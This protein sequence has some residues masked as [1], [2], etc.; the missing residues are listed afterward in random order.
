MAVHEESNPL[1]LYHADEQNRQLRCNNYAIR[2]RYA[3]GLV[4][5]QQNHER[6]RPQGLCA[7]FV[8]PVVDTYIGTFISSMP[9]IAITSCLERYRAVS[10]ALTDIFQERVWQ[11]QAI[12]ALIARILNDCFVC[13]PGIFKVTWDPTYY[14]D[15]VMDLGRWMAGPQRRYKLSDFLSVEH[16][17]GEAQIN[18]DTYGEIRISRVSPGSFGAEPGAPSLDECEFVYTK[19]SIPRRLALEL[20]PD[21]QKISPEPG[22]EP[23]ITEVTPSGE[24]RNRSRCSIIEIWY[25]GGAR[26]ATLVNRQLVDNVENPYKYVGFPF[27]LFY[28]TIPDE[29]IFPEDSLVEFAATIHD[30]LNVELRKYPENSTI[31]GNPVLIDFTQDKQKNKL[32]RRGPNTVWKAD[33]V[34]DG[35]AYKYLE[36]PNL[37]S[38]IRWFVETMFQALQFTTGAQDVLIG[39]RPAGATSGVAIASLQE[40]SVQKMLP[41]RTLFHAGLQQVGEIMLGLASQFY[42]VPDQRAGRIEPYIREEDRPPM[43]ID[44]QTGAPLPETPIE[45]P[46]NFRAAFQVQVEPLS[47]FA[48]S[49]TIQAQQDLELL[50]TPGEDGKP[51]ITRE[52]YLAKIKYPG[53]RQ[54][55]AQYRQQNTPPIA[56]QGPPG[57]NGQPA[58]QLP[59]GLVQQQVQQMQQMPQPPT[60]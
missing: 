8:K 30:A 10:N 22:L 17:M 15:P 57:G 43:Q 39:E 56:P 58:A 1:A 21:Y 11:D 52:A 59:P 25:D 6:R 26:I 28:S 19:S 42:A 45:Y 23:I 32:Q 54:I 49:Q 35:P 9:T 24:P 60:Q 38:D 18:P 53:R 37:P 44:P 13:N 40:K 55:I 33:P 12:L 20:Y 3:R 51:L 31:V 4:Q 48:V 7:N 34:A 14:G 46:D 27:S 36:A 16:A 50:R 29:N 2:R 5:P 41:L 47:N